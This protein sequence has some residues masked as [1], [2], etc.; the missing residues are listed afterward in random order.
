IA[1]TRVAALGP[2]D[3]STARAR[4]ALAE[5]AFTM[6]RSSE[7]DSVSRDVL[8]RLPDG[9]ATTHPLAAV[10]E[11]RIGPVIKNILGPWQ[12]D[13][14]VAHHTRALAILARCGAAN[15]ILAA[16]VHR[17]I[18]N[19]ERPVGNIP[20]ALAQLQQALT[21]LSARPVEAGDR[22]PSTWT[23]TAY[24]WATQ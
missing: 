14:S 10:A 20:E 6:G 24:L 7:A 17:E 22:L 16:D 5:V 12:R 8:A 9:P 15:S 2:A 3:L 13:S 21:I 18:A 11:Q 4:V 23:D 1:E 19:A